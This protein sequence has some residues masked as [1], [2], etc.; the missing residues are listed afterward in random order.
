MSVTKALE[1]WLK[2]RYS[3]R[4][5]T[6]VEG[7]SQRFKH[8]SSNFNPQPADRTTKDVGRQLLA[9]LGNRC[10]AP[11]RR[12]IRRADRPHVGPHGLGSGSALYRTRVS[13]SCKCPCASC[14]CSTVPSSPQSLRAGK[15]FQA[16]NAE[17]KFPNDYDG[18]VDFCSTNTVQKPISFKTLYRS[19]ATRTHVTGL[20][21]Q[22]RS[23]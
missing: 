13:T 12:P 14:C 3:G 5:W 11:P 4:L 15:L 17:C 23:E 7:S 10:A 22:I 16:K 21:S 1:T 2:A 18:N 19:K 8:V 20:P 6:L 9:E